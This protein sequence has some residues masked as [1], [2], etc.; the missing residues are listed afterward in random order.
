MEALKL[1]RLLEAFQDLHRCPDERF[2]NQGELMNLQNLGRSY[3]ARDAMDSG[4]RVARADF[5]YRVP[6][7]GFGPLEAQQVW[8]L[9]L[10]HAIHVGDAL[11]A[12]DFED[13]ARVSKTLVAWADQNLVGIPVRP[14]DWRLLTETLPVRT[15]EFHLSYQDVRGGLS[16]DG[17]PSLCNYSVHLPDYVNATHLINPFSVE[18]D[19]RE[20]SQTVLHSCMNFA[21]ELQELSGLAVRV[22]GSFSSGLGDS[23]E[24][25]YEGQR[26]LVEA[27][28]RSSVALVHQWL[29]PYAWYFGGSVP[30]ERFN[31]LE[32]LELCI[33]YDIPLCLD[34]AHAAMCVNAGRILVDD[35]S[36]LATSLTVHS[37]VSGASGVDAEGIPLDAADE[38][39]RELIDLVM[40]LPILKIL[41]RWQGHLNK[42][43]GFVKDVITLHSLY[44]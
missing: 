42:G 24:S 7:R 23:R 5:D 18:P 14:R 27:W 35:F 37:H 25:F 29:P 4:T 3:Y 15:R 8:G 16:A 10:K 43:R 36:R 22:V 39:S 2:P 44:S 17:L 19:I 41:E 13:T 11:G 34:T 31:S 20:E 12:G 26:E 33:A 6:R 32:D 28:N 9:P 40:G 30:I 21:R 38:T 1:W